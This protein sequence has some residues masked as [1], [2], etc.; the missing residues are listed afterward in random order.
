[1]VG[2]AKSERKKINRDPTGDEKDNNIRGVCDLV[3]YVVFL[4]ILS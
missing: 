4:D 1:M 3:D 2:F